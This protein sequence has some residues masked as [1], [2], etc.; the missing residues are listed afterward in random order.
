M[1]YKINLKVC[2]ISLLIIFFTFQRVLVNYNNIFSYV[3]EIFC[4]YIVVIM[5]MKIKLNK[6]DLNKNELNILLL[7]ILLTVVGLVG[8]ITSNL[9]TN[10]LQIIVD[11]ISTVKIWISFY[12]LFLIQKD[13]AFF[14]RII[15]GLAKF[16]RFVVLIMFVCFL[17]SQVVNLGMTSEVR[18][19]I[20]SF[21][22]VFNNPGNFSKLFYFLIPLLT[23]DLYYKSNRYKKNMILLTLIVWVFTLRSR[24]ISFTAL[25]LLLAFFFFRHDNSKI[26]K[27]I[28]VIKKK[29][30]FIYLLPILIVIIFLSKNQILFYFT[31]STQARSILL[32][33]GIV[34]AKTYFPVGAGFG[35][36]GSDVAAN[37]YSLLYR[38]YGFNN[39]YGMR[40][41]ETNF[42]NDNYWPMIVGQFGA[43]GTIIVFVIL[44]IYT[45]N[46]L[47]CV[48]NNKIFYFSIFISSMFLL[49]SSVA[50]KSY[51][52]YSSICIFLLM[53]LLVRKERE[54]EKLIV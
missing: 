22:F 41:D 24:A 12:Y 30:K 7:L 50:S 47:N 44:I 42:L 20:K 23:A 1:N 13:E 15:I 2:F 19:G 29:I 32:R 45:K 38:R 25:Y 8:N 11:I 34:T 54:H 43:I 28:N 36:Y 46:V 4:I 16:F 26:N 49:L 9:F 6:V 33:Y 35:T 21:K 27:Q 40:Q 17:I 14:D 37:N 10:K 53:S 52:E 18:Y 3:D 5:F 39:F 31:N 48:K 51:S